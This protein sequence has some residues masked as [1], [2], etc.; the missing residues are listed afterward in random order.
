MCL[1][2]DKFFHNVRRADAPNG[3]GII[4]EVALN[5][6]KEAGRCASPRRKGVDGIECMGMADGP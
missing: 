3:Q 4:L 5:A 2:I 6:R 1:N